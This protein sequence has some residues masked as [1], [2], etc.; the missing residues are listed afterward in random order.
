M[1]HGEGRDP[2]AGGRLAQFGKDGEAEGAGG[3][4]GELWG[5][6]GRV[7]G[8]VQEL[9]KHSLDVHAA[10]CE[11]G[12]HASTGIRATRAIRSATLTPGSFRPRS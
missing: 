7:P 8:P 10:P 1:S 4:A 2:E 5:D 9:V 6:L 11:S 3:F 12:S